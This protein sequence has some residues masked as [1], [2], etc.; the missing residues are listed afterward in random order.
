MIDHRHMT[1]LLAGLTCVGVNGAWAQDNPW[2]TTPRTPPAMTSGGEERGFT[3]GYLRGF[4][5]GYRRGAEQATGGAPTA[6]LGGRTAPAAT[7]A[8][9]RDFPTAVDDNGVQRPRDAAAP[10]PGPAPLSG[11][12]PGVGA[13]G[14]TEAAP[15]RTPTR[16][17][18]EYPPLDGDRRAAQPLSG[19]S[20][21]QPPTRS[22][23][24]SR[25]AAA[26]YP[27][28]GP[29]PYSAAAGATTAQPTA[30]YAS[31]YAAPYGHYG[32]G[33]PLGGPSTL[34]GPY[35]GFGGPFGAGPLPGIPFFG[36]F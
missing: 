11:G 16:L 14:S 23:P 20:Q 15:A 31:P 33:A 24:A 10:P 19:S 25:A 1:V 17:W 5:Q 8:V 7:G 2:R 18:G 29:Y 13:M 30:P 32:Y 12:Y 9:R 26:G 21:A 36:A 34:H 28:A 22:E 4:E 35:G 6:N 3:Q 27:Y